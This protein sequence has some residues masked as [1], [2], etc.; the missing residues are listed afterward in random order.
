MLAFAVG[1]LFIIL[2]FGRVEGEEF[3]P[4]T[5]RQRRYVYYEIPLVRKQVRPISRMDSSSS[6]ATYLS[7]QGYVAVVAPKSARWDPL[8]DNKTAANAPDFDA[9]YLTAYLNQYDSEYGNFWESWS[10]THPNQA[11]AFW[12]VVVKLA[13]QGEYL[14][15]SDL[16]R[17][18][19]QSQSPAKLRKQMRTICT[20][21][22]ILKSESMAEQGREEK[23]ESLNQLLGEITQEL[24]GGS[25]SDVPAQAEDPD[26]S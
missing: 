17:A 8:W 6:I 3:S 14:C 19:E 20:D 26:Q 7:G 2:V 22:L 18:A 12:P 10:V 4:D 15:M 21:Y 9:Q 25:E 1:S 11:A 13:S 5:F 16:F 24:E 23:A